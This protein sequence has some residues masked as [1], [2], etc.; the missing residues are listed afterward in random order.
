[1]TMSSFT[2]GTTETQRKE[3]EGCTMREDLH[4]TISGGFLTSK[5]TIKLT[6]FTQ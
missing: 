2:L 1:M 4:S 3:E 6:Y 5:I